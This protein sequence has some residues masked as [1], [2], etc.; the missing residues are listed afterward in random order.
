MLRPLENKVIVKRKPAEE[1]T[2][3]G[4]IIPSSAKEKTQEG[5]VKSVGTGKDGKELPLKAGQ[6]VLY[7]KYSGTE[8]KYNNEEL[9][10]LDIKDI[11]AIVE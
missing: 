6:T 11:L 3:G 7:E 1:K 2:A 5:I 10:V 8:L 9:V 4:I